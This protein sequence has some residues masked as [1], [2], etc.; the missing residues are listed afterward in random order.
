MRR[1]RWIVLLCFIAAIVALAGICS[2]TAGRNK[3]RASAAAVSASPTPSLPLIEVRRGRLDS[4]LYLDGELRAVRSRTIFADTT[5]EAKIVFLAPEGSVVKAGERL[6]ELDSS[7]IAGKIKE[8]EEAVIAAENEIVKLRSTQEAALR[9]MEVE[10]SR[11]WLS[12]EQGRIKADIPP[13][14]VARRE[15]QEYQL[16]RDK[17]KADHD[18]QLAKIEKKKKEQA[19]ELEV[20]L[21]DKKKLEVQL[22]RVRANLE[23]MRLSAPQ[24]GMVIYS[25]HWNWNERRK[26]QVGD[27]VWS[28]LPILRLPDLSQMEVLARVNEVDGPRLKVGQKAVIRLDSYPDVQVQ[29]SVQE[30]SETAVKT[31]WMGKAKVFSVVFSLDQTLTH[32]MKPGLSAQIALDLDG[33]P[34]RLLLLRSAVRFDSGAAKV[35]RRDADGV[36]RAVPVTITGSDVMRFSV[37]EDGALRAGDRIAARWQGL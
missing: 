17:A 6:V 10:L 25:E 31:S 37:A 11:L 3:V 9:D 1:A 34:E 4:R 13:E 19:A 16:A 15:Y 14:I 8:A 20:R 29:G 24:D 32:I 28:G 26:I 12:Y 5:D 23:A 27:V 2:R 21:I 22:S 36:D 33:V 35:L 18:N 30:I 7:A